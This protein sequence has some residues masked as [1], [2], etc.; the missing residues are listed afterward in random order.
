[1]IACQ[2]FSCGAVSPPEGYHNEQDLTKPYPDC[3]INLVKD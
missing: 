2:N 3:C 1:M